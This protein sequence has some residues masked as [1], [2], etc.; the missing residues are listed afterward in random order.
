[1]G[2]FR[3]ILMWCV[4]LGILLLV[5][6]SVL[7]AFLGPVLA[8]A[9]FNSAPLVVL[10]AILAVMLAVGLFAWKKMIRSPGL[11]AIHLGCLLVLLGGMWGSDLA[12][13]LR[14]KWSGQKKPPKAYMV[15]G[16]GETDNHLMEQDAEG[17]IRTIGQLNVY[18]KPERMWTEYYPSDSLRQTD[19]F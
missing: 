7:A 19:V 16:E 18:L 15:L 10:W 14:E 1:M 17:N 13:A 8:K 9:M 6:L 5:A 11:L 4:L 3:R 2:G 12:H